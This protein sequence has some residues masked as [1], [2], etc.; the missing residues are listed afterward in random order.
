MLR[1]SLVYNHRVSR[2]VK[3]AMDEFVRPFKISRKTFKI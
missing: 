2:L 3:A 1:C